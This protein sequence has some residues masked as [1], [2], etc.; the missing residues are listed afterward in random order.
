MAL[1]FARILA[2]IGSGLSAAGQPGGNFSQGVMQGVGFHDQRLDR[3]QQ[4]E[5][6]KLLDEIRRIQIEEARTANAETA[7]RRQA[8]SDWLSSKE[9]IMS[10]A[11]GFSQSQFGGAPRGP[12]QDGWTPEKMA[13]AK[14]NP[15]LAAQAMAAEYFPQQEKPKTTDD[16]LEY[17]FYR[18]QGG[19]AD[20]TSWMRDNKKAGASNTSVT[21]G[22]PKSILA[23]DETF[24][25]TG[26]E[27]YLQAQ[28]ILPL[29][30]IAREASKKFSQSGPLG[31]A[32]LM[33]ERLKSYFGMDNNASAGEVLQGMQTRLGTLLRVPGSGATSNYEMG[34]YMQGVPGLLNS[35]QGNVALADIGEKLVK[36]RMRDFE[37]YRDY[38]AKNG[39]GIG[40]V[41]D[42]T[43]VLTPEEIQMLMGG[44]STPE[45]PQSNVPQPGEVQ[46]GYRFKGGNPGD[47]ANWE[48]VEGQAY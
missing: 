7:N 6:D 9:G 22:A 13:F 1:D 47:P 43:P 37:R 25:K 20:F 12:M 31:G 29:F 26:A 5:R 40:Y 23:S 32:A 42:E 41:P 48:K 46:D 39:N 36:R 16:L 18:D 4:Q 45:T 33:T 3:Q 15:D 30:G 35:Q 27:G 44:S 10:P 24:L 21:V 11:N 8:V 34:L 28:E 2:G 19:D 14:A 38:V 17:Q